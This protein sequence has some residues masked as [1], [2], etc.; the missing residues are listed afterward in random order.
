MFYNVNHKY[1]REII[2]VKEILKRK[3]CKCQEFENI[4]V[5]QKFKDKKDGKSDN[6]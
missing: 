2:K 4:N 6:V 1:F 3:L 5:K